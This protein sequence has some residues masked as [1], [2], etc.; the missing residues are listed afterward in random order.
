MSRVTL[1]N[2]VVVDLKR[3]FPSR[4]GVRGLK[5]PWKAHTERGR[6]APSTLMADLFLSREE[7]IHH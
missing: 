3:P 2:M 6:A 7:K 1:F 4:R 5:Q